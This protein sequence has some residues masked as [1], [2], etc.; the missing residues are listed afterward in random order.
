MFDVRE[1]HRYSSKVRRLFLEKLATLP[2]DE[3]TK[4]REASF[5]SMRNIIIH[6]I[7]NEDWMVNWV[8]RNRATEYKRTRKSD[9]Y[10][11]MQMIMVHLESV[12]FK[13]K[14][15]LGKADEAE[16]QRT[17][18]LTI[19]TGHS[20]ELSVEECLFQSF[21][22]QLYH[23]GELIALLWQDNIEPPKMQWFWNNPRH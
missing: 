22:E 18:T 8:I 5:Y 10:T 12:E 3:V 15:Y 2:W 17:V 13:T 20:F 7:D 16:L 21:T 19:S 23:L 1:L 14:E 4:N 11:N 6:I 9:D